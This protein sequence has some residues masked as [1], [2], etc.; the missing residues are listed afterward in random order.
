MLRPS[1]S[2]WFRFN[3]AYADTPALTDFFNAIRPERA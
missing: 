2:I 1:S 3:V